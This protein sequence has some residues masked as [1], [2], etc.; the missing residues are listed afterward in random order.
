MKKTNV[1]DYRSYKVYLL[2]WIKQSPAGGRG[3]RKFLAQAIGCQTPFVTQVLGGDYQFSLE[4]V[5]ACAR[6][7]GLTS[8]ESEFLLLLAIRERAG[9]KSLAAMAER[10]LAERRDRETQLSSRLK[11]SDTLTNEDQ[12]QYYSSWHYAAVHM[13]VMNPAL[14]TVAELQRHFEMPLPR[15]IAVL[16]FLEAKK[17]LRGKAGRYEVARSVLHLGRE[18]RLL[19][20]HHANWRLR[21]IEAVE[22]G[23]ASDFHYS[24]V[25]SLSG[26][27]FEWI[28]AQLGVM[29]EESIARLKNSP[30]ERL[31]CLSMDLF[32]V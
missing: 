14:R 27:D 10:Q 1:F 17:L 32:E 6:W 9:T 15:L 25:I 19:A 3:Q 22:I 5:E 30:D 20:K 7:L 12:I 11:I 23:S 29:L 2:D 18:S 13:A 31:A 21:A 28:K 16:E 26:D 24:G 4:Q 8:A